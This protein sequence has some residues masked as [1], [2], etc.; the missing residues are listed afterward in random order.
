MPGGG[1]GG[2]R[3]VVFVV[4]VAVVVL[5]GVVDGLFAFFEDVF[6][7]PFVG[8]IGREHD[9]DLLAHLAGRGVGM[10]HAGEFFQGALD[11][12][13]TE[14]G[15][16]HFATAEFQAKFHLVAVV[17]EFLRVFHLGE[18]VA[19]LDARGELDLFDLG[20]RCLHVAGFFLLFID[21]LA[22]VHDAADGGIG[23]RGH[24]DQV[25][26]ELL[27][28]RERPVRG[29]DAELFAFGGNHPDFGNP[30]AL[31]APDMREWVVVTTL[32]LAGS[33][34]ATLGK[35]NSHQ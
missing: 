32:I 4:V 16:G 26:I 3:V 6:A 18:K 24:L 22:E 1:G 35:R 13:K 23:G 10:A 2:A 29:H 28:E 7:L 14:F 8:R 5:A 27:G 20:G 31:V 34:A 11:H 17:E 30:D 33:P 9:V 15:T 21:I 19:F 25:E 12:V